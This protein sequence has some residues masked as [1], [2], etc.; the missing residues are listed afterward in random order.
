MEAL[1]QEFNTRVFANDKS[2]SVLLK[3]K[4]KMVEKF[5][6][7][8]LQKVL[9]SELNFL[10]RKVLVNRLV[11]DWNNTQVKTG[12]AVGVI[13][14]Q[15]IGERATQQSMKTLHTAGI[16]LGKSS[17]QGISRIEEIL[18][19]KK[20]PAKPSMKFFIK[21]KDITS[22][23]AKVI[24]GLFQFVIFSDIVLRRKTTSFNPKDEPTW[25]K[26]HRTIFPKL[27][28][29]FESDTSVHFTYTIDTKKCYMKRLDFYR[30][31]QRIKS[32]FQFQKIDPVYV[33]FSDFMTGEIH[34]LFTTSTLSKIEKKFNVQQHLNQIINNT[35][36]SGVK[37]IINVFASNY[38]LNSFITSWSQKGGDVVGF[39]N[40]KELKRT[41]VPKSVVLEY[42]KNRTGKDVSENLVV[43]DVIRD[44]FLSDLARV[45]EKLEKVCNIYEQNEFIYIDYP[46]PS[47]GVDTLDI[48]SAF[49]V[50]I[51]QNKQKG[52]KISKQDMKLEDVKNIRVP[53]KKRVEQGKYWYWETDGCNMRGMFI[54]DG[55]F[56]RDNGQTERIDIILDKMTSNHIPEITKTLGIEAGKQLV[57]DE[58]VGSTS[59][60]HPAHLSIFADVLTAHGYMIQVGRH[61]L[62]K[63][64]AGHLSTA[65]F[66]EMTKHMVG[67]GA[68]GPIDQM[69]SIDAATIGGTL[70]KVGGQVSEKV[71]QEERERGRFLAKMFK[72]PILEPEQKAK[73]RR[74][75]ETRPER[76]VERE[77]EKKSEKLEEEGV[78]EF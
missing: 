78:L 66:E 6:R 44:P 52:Y 63:T 13:A 74:V 3:S 26:I 40:E 21:N 29:E 32:E 7:K 24:T 48:I 25:F 41:L 37:D 56:L 65:S 8:Q 75:R 45:D 47:S 55:E 22:T 58:L 49:V 39:W 1:L 4:K 67:S 36:I 53:N 42:I 54:F 77:P 72:K 57:I 46:D 34:V 20:V 69:N 5:F 18:D 17:L 62:L 11:E 50:E 19:V 2:P 73:P 23:E 14:A 16:S 35:V 27:N 71:A 10:Q 68:F 33:Y 15:S 30:I 59:D 28:T 38:E 51:T 76:K 64:G 60:V 43:K 12:K 31:A 61:G 9:L 70:P